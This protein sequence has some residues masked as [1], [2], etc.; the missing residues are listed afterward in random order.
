MENKKSN[1][2]PFAHA[3]SNK[4]GISPVIATVLLVVMVVVIALIVFLWFRNINQEAITK[5]DGTNVEIIC[6]DVQFESSYSSETLYISNNGNVPIYS[7]KLKISSGGSYVT[8]DLHEIT[9]S[10]WPEN[11]LNPG[12]A[13]S[14]TGLSSSL[15]TA[16]KVVLIP[17]L[18]GVTDSGE[19]KMHTC[20]DSF[21]QTLAI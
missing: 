10:D 13:F 2:A 9:S 21:G 4:R 14:S 8:D 3:W 6:G 18:V 17:V 12:N 15:D 16:D 19:K 5:F 1:S 20:A 7:I 11:G